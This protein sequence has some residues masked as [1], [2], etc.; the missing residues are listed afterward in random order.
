MHIALDC[1]TGMTHQEHR[2]FLVFVHVRIAHR[3]AV[4]NQGVVQQVAIAIRGV[5][6]LLEKIRK[7]GHVIGIQPGKFR[8]CLGVFTVVRN[9]V[10]GSLY[11]G[12]RV[13]AGTDVT[14]HLE[15]RNPGGIGH[16][17]QSLQIEHQSNVFIEGIGHSDRCI[18]QFTAV[19]G[20]V[21][22]LDLLD[23]A[24]N[25]AHIVQIAVQARPVARVQ[26]LLQSVHSLGDGVQNAAVF[27]A[28]QAAFLRRAARAKQALEGHAGIHF[29]GQRSGGRGPGNRVGVNAAVA[30][31]ASAGK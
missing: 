7:R 30:I 18:R 22:L 17:R 29:H 20:D 2:D 12:S 19:T 5:L 14:A 27:G 25:L 23:A 4:H 1:A 24:L 6:Q 3:T 28:A 15:C 21:E 26:S 11:T 10:E 8:N 13:H 9:G 16:E 31:A